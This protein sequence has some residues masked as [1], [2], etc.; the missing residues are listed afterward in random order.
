MTATNS[1]LDDRIAMVTACTTLGL[2]TGSRNRDDVLTNQEWNQLAQWLGKQKMRPADLLF[3]GISNLT[4]DGLDPQLALKA[5]SIAER[6]SIAALEIEQLESVGIWTL[7]RIDES[8]PQRWKMRL[9]S[10]APPVIFGSG[11]VALMDRPS[12]AIVGSREIT[13]ELA[14][15]ANSIGLRVAQAGMVVV[16]GGARGPT[17]L[18]C[19]ERC[20]PRARQSACLRPI[21]Q[22]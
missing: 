7:S 13:E 20:K 2:S 17:E 9:K 19:R 10:A 8:Y 18:V 14:K 5:N 21:W 1:A 4:S 3:A 22:D 6:A 12:I 15:I 11:P 16:S